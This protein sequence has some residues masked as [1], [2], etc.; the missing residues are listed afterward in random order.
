MCL[1]IFCVNVKF[2]QNIIQT[3]TINDNKNQTLWDEINKLESN[4]LKIKLHKKC[5]EKCTKAQL[6]W[7]MWLVFEIVIEMCLKWLSWSEN[8]H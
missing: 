3:I 6:H 5:N 7:Q 8:N 4:S 1:F 2:N